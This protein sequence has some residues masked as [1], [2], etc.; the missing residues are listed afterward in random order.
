MSNSQNIVDLM[1]E[2]QRLRERVQTLRRAF[3]SVTELPCCDSK[4]PGCKACSTIDIFVREVLNTDDKSQDGV[5]ISINS[6][7]PL[8]IYME[9]LERGDSE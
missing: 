6:R 7:N 5:G 2:N 4:Y 1:R 9:S 3:D 8:A